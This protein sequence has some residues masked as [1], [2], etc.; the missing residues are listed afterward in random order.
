[1]AERTQIMV[2]AASREGAGQGTDARLFD[3]PSRSAESFYCSCGRLTACR[4]GL[5]RRVLAGI[6]ELDI[7]A[8]SII[9]SGMKVAAVE[10]AGLG[11]GGLITIVPDLGIL[12]GD[13][14]AHDSEAQPTVRIRIQYR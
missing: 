5:S 7:V 6:G 4:S 13:H 1:M 9:R 11:L 10:G 12:V 3:G 8:D 14:H 2:S